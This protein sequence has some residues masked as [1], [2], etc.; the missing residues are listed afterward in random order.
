[1]NI[2]KAKGIT[3]VQILEKLGLQP[4]RSN[5]KES[6]YL[7]PF[8]IEKTPSFHVHHDKNLW[9]D[10]G[11]AK[12]GD[13]IRLAQ[14]LLEQQGVDSS[15]SAALVWLDNNVPNPIIKPPNAIRTKEE[16]SPVL[17][18]KSAKP[19]KNLALIH[20]LKKRGIPLSTANK[21]LKEITFVNRTSGKTIFALGLENEEEGY[22]LRNSFF[23]GVI[24]KK[25]ISFI[26]GTQPKP[27]GINVFEGMFDY[28]SV[29]TQRNGKSLK[30]DTIILNSINCIDQIVPYIKNYGYQSGYTWLDNDLAGKKAVPKIFEMFKMENIAFCPMNSL[31]QPYKDVNAAHMAKLELA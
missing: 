18:F 6:W 11:E 20:Y 4:K 22:E 13:I 9:F 24:G 7:S 23:K 31:Y 30:N 10:F 25:S 17:E 15:V 8:R 2:E 14:A 16:H 1:M 19:I 21:A 26:R 29:I 12:G 27:S 5:K 28:L 3:I